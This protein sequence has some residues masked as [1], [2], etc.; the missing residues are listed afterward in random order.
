LKSFRFVFQFLRKYSVAL[1]VT[2]VSMLLLVGVQLVGPW[3]IKQ[4]VA[5][6]SS[7]G[8]AQSDMLQITRLALLALSVYLLRILF[9]YLR[10]YQAHIAGWGVVADV[11]LKL[12]EH[13]Q[14][15]SLRFY[16]NT[17]TG[18]LMSQLVN[19]TDLLENLIAHAIPDLSANVLTL[20]GVLVILFSINA[21]LALLSMIPVPLII[22]TMQAFNKFV[23]R[24]SVNASASWAS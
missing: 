18:D 14:R 24:P 2:I 7:P 21:P 12:Y 19:D 22:L 3:L 13:V 4:M 6:V 9:Q 11:R 8:L 17:Q 10:S 15:L 23:N 1:V 5:I 20:A 16:E